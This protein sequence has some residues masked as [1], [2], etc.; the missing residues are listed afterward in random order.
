MLRR[1]E[2]EEEGEV[3]RVEVESE[4]AF[5]FRFQRRRAQKKKPRVSPAAHPQSNLSRPLRLETARSDRVG[6]EERKRVVKGGAGE[7]DRGKRRNAESARRRRR[8]LVRPLARSALPS[9][10]KTHFRVG[11]VVV[12]TRVGQSGRPSDA[13]GPQGE[14]AAAEEGGEGH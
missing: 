12:R 10:E 5:V 6:R 3:E 4:R 11:L 7:R 8:R 13:H 14:Q 1:G 2:E 9:Q